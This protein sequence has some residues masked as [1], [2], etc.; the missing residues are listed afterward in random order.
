[1]LDMQQ[2]LKN[3]NIKG[4]KLG[5]QENKISNKFEE[6]TEKKASEEIKGLEPFKEMETPSN[7]THWTWPIE[8]SFIKYY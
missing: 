5:N 6:E 8:G 1:M 2:N 3:L 4:R 7:K